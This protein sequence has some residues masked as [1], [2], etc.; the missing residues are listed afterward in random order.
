MTESIHSKRN[1]SIKWILIALLFLLTTLLYDR[2]YD[3]TYYYNLYQNIIQNELNLVFEKI[4]SIS[5]DIQFQNLYSSNDS[6]SVKDYNNYLYLKEKK[7][8]L[9]GINVY[10][11]NNCIF[12]SN[13]KYAQTTLPQINTNYF[14]D[15]LYNY[16]IELKNKII[17][18]DT[19][20]TASL[21][22]LEQKTANLN[23]VFSSKSLISDK[24][25]DQISI[26]KYTK[27][28][29]LP[30]FGRNKIP[31]ANLHPNGNIESKPH[32][33]T[34]IILYFI[35]IIL[36][37]IGIVRF[38]EYLID[39]FS[40]LIGSGFLM[41]TTFGLRMLTVY[42][43]FG[44]R[45]KT[46]PGFE[47][48]LNSAFLSHSL[49]D[50][51][52]NIVLLMCVMTFF[53][54]KLKSRSYDHLNKTIKLLLT[55]LNYFAIITGLLM[56]SALYKGIVLNSGIN[57][58]FDNVLNMDEYS[59]MAIVAAILMQ[60]TLFM[61]SHKMMSIILEIG[62]SR[63][64]R[65]LALGIAILISIPV[66]SI[67][68]LEFHYIYLLLGTLVY[69]GLFDLF[70]DNES[71]NFTWLV[72]WLVVFSGFSTALLYKYN[73]DKEISTRFSY[74][75]SL[76]TGENS[77][78]RTLKNR[79]DKVYDL[80]LTNLSND[81]ETSIS[82]YDY[83]V[84]L[85]HQCIEKST[86][87]YRQVLDTTSFILPAKGQYNI[88][89]TSK[90][91]LKNIQRSELIYHHDD[92]SVVIV[93]KDYQTVIK[94]LSL[95]C[96]LFSLI[97]LSVT[98]ITLI[99]TFTGILPDV[100]Q[101][102]L[103]GKPTLKSKIQLSVISL[104]V[105][106]FIIIGV[107]TVLY[108]RDSAGDAKESRKLKTVSLLINDCKNQLELLK[109][110]KDILIKFAAFIPT[111]SFLHQVDIDLYDTNGRVIATSKKEI[112]NK[113]IRKPFIP[114]LPL[115]YMQTTLKKPDFEVETYG[116]LKYMSQF[117]P[118]TM[119]SGELI[120]FLGI[121]LEVENIT[122]GTEVTEFMGTLLNV[123]VFLLLIAAVIAIAVANSITRPIGLIGEKL[124]Q[125]KL[126][127]SNEPLQWNSP[128][129]IGE[130]IS[131]YNKMIV[132][133]EESAQLLAQSER[134]G[135]WREMA[136]QV[137]HE[138]NN[139]LTPMK[140]NIQYLQ[141]AY[142]NQQDN[143]E[144]IFKKVSKTL[145]EQIETLTQIASEFS[146]VAKMPSGKAEIV[147]IQ[148]VINSII[149]LFA[150]MKNIT[151]SRDLTEQKLYV[152]MD[153]SQLSRVLTNVV[154]NATQSIP[155]NKTGL[156]EVS[157]HV[158]E[159]NAIIRVKD[160][161]IGIPLG[162]K[163]KVFNPNFT[164]KSSGTGLGLAMS[165]SIIESAN[166]F[167]YFESSENMGATFTIEL[168]LHEG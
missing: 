137:A 74:A 45:F 62:L 10:K 123:Y 88:I 130:L 85:Q 107:V 96:Y 11:N 20:I 8:D 143:I 2:I 92:G 84:Y 52:I 67:F 97:L 6:L 141:H 53:H 149:I 159:K 103:K 44:L 43:D 122:L 127:A 132:K 77:Q 57:F 136:K 98:L 142:E 146:N 29:E 7:T 147:N 69:V 16:Y 86:E 22:P 129:E 79:N 160:N 152:F 46:I 102:S 60:V 59:M 36:F 4:D 135:A 126:G 89:I 78:L 119:P 104:T 9:Y 150:E 73:L 106:S 34:L 21:I 71:Y 50:L 3:E 131:E 35:A 133:L 112:Y 25:T 63:N 163:D 91:G 41:L 81:K 23:A 38:S 48:N 99:N 139:P 47:R 144:A 165:K 70:I 134:E 168:P 90:G 19:F 121:P 157:L 110:E 148:S 51:L 118:L 101:L 17:G 140:L 151:I 72:I 82:K 161:G 1:S 125:F 83:A 100:M 64:A 31:F 39:R 162:K 30:L 5:D 156:I 80:L 116:N 105:F 113:G 18:K 154:K 111:I 66:A 13:Q 158:K 49:A 58:D 87:L 120:G 117:T 145:I 93:G 94:V 109:N 155:E 68:D 24:I 153:K 164:T 76:R 166:G 61:F 167:I 27:N 138:I 28:G 115:E 65:L 37:A 14:Q 32:Q 128:D 12:W 75:K 42:F 26:V 95:F 55:S 15:S 54:K 40:L 124:K 114:P 56:T 108:F 33:V